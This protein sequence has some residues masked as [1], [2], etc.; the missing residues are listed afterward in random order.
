MSDKSNTYGY[1]SGGP[2]QAAG[3]NDGVFEVNDIVGLLTDSQWSLQVFDVEWLVAAGGG[4]SGTG[5]DAPGGGGAGGFRNSFGSENTGGGL[6]GEAV[7]ADVS[8]DGTTTYTVTVGA[9]GSTNSKGSNSVFNTITSEGGGS[10]GASNNQ[11]GGT[12]GNGGSGGGGGHA[13]ANGGTGT[14]GQGF[15][16]AAGNSSDASNHQ[17]GGGGGAGE[18][19]E[20]NSTRADGVTSSI[21]G[22]AV[23]YAKGGKRGSTSGPVAGDVAVANTGDGGNAGGSGLTSR[24]GASGVVILRY[25]AGNTI[26]V[27]SGLTSSTATDGDKKVTTFTAGTD[28]ITFS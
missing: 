23:E 20:T 5:N 2:T 3:D 25:P 4:G 27:G 14:S 8:P 22:S 10:G 26:T 11:S 7:L 17:G 13:S 16:G 6:S 19:G 24:P 12:G 9:G 15:N 28:T 1:V 21:T 18:A